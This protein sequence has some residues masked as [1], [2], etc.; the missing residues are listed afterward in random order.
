[1]WY[2]PEDSTSSWSQN[3]FKEDLLEPYPGLIAPSPA[4]IIPLPDKVF[5]N[6]SPSKE[7]PKVPNNIP[8][9]PPLCSLA[10][11]LIVS[12]TPFNSTPESSEI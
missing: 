12:L 4:L 1:M 11:F 8:R 9:N 2:V 5:V 3:F 6:R 10:S 7:A